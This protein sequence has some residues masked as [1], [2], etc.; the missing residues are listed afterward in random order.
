MNTQDTYTRDIYFKRALFMN[1]LRYL[2]GDELFFP[3]LKKLATDPIY[4]YNNFVTTDDVE[5]LFSNE[6][7]MN[8]KPLFDFYLRTTSL[9]EITIRQTGITS[10]VVQAKKIPMTLPIEI[11]G[12]NG[13]GKVSLTT[14]PFRIESTTP[15]VIDPGGHYLKRVIIE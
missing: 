8:L 1:T 13:S 14:E 11:S 5:K 2:T 3:T 10:W 12:S 4:T 15:P 6:S 7:K 9:L